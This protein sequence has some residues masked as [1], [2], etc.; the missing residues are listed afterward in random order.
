MR[1][2]CTPPREYSLQVIGFVSEKS[3]WGRCVTSF[4]SF[5]CVQ[6]M[7]VGNG[8]MSLP[9]TNPAAFLT[10]AHTQTH[11]HVGT[12]LFISYFVSTHPE[13]SGKSSF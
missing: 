12:M 10:S 3:G 5:G 13:K 11:C 1:L 9:T 7:G 6:R 8:M 4:L 2:V